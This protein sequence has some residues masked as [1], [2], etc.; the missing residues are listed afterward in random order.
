[1][2]AARRVARWLAWLVS[3]AC[4]AAC[5]SDDDAA[6]ADASAGAADAA[7]ITDGGAPIGGGP[8]HDG[9]ASSWWR[10]TPGTS[11]QWQLT[12]TIDTSFDVHMYDLDLFD[13]PQTIINRLHGDG[14]IVVCYFSAGSYENWRPDADDLP[15]SARGNPL[16]GWPG[17][18]WLDVRDP[19]VRAVMRAR[20]DRAASRGCD[21]VEP[22]NVDGYDNDPGFA[23]TAADQL[24]YNR[25]LAAEA[26]ARGLSVGLKNDL[27]QI[28]Q[29]LD[30]FDWSLD[31]QCFELDECDA[32]TPFIS[33]GKPVFNV[34]YGGSP[35]AAQVCP[36]ANAR[37]FDTLI[38]DLDLDAR[39]IACR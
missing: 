13:T 11:W 8:R 25:F 38:K 19:G 16:D 31:E 22:D 27:A 14:R 7:A 4:A 9:G 20:L 36:S 3:L 29:L 1:M 33:A 37:N 24:D 5:S 30:D 32:L 2:T 6:R 15:A 34:E 17:E 23:L 18:R 12:G 26:H 39:R 28:D 10:P 35:L 21:G